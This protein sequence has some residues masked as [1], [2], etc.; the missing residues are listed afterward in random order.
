[1]TTVKFNVGYGK[2]A[3]QSPKLP[4]AVTSHDLF[5]TRIWQ[6]RLHKLAPRFPDWV[7]EVEAMR[8]ASTSTAGRTNRHGW[9]SADFALFDQ[10]LFVDLREAITGLC[11]DALRQIHGAPVAFELMS[12]V[13]IHDRGGLNLPHMHEGC[14]LSGCFYLQVPQGSGPLVLRDPRPGV[15]M[16]LVKGGG[17]NAH[18]DVRLQPENGLAVLFPSWLEHFVEMHEH[19]IARISLP[20]NALMP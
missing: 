18:T 15:A 16:G 19:D 3:P 13:N 2:Q 17:P 7:A 20:F 6:A 12:W 14:L 4:V 8:A 10:P 11:A 9:N 1:M 5:A